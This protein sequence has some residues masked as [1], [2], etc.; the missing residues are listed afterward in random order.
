MSLFKKNNKRSEKRNFLNASDE[1]LARA[2]GIEV[3][4]LPSSKAKEATFYTCLRI[5]SDTVSKVPLKMYK[6]TANGTEKATGH[7]LYNKLKLRPNKNMSASDFWKMVEYQR[8]YYG[9]SVVVIETLPNGKVNGLHPLNMEFTEVWMDD[10]GIIGK[11]ASYWYVYKHQVGERI[12][13]FKFHSDEVLHFKGMTKDGI[14]GMAVKDY[15]ATNIEN[16]Q[17]GTKYTNEYFKGGLQA[18]GILQYTGDVD[19]VGMNRLKERFEKM[20]TGMNNV[21]KIL[22]VPVG[23]SF[24]TLNTSMAD[25]QFFENMKLSMQQIASAFG[26]KNHQLNDLSGAKFNNVASQNDE[27]YR[28]TLLPIFTAYEMELTYKLL[29]TKEIEEGMFFQFNV[30]VILRTSLETRYKAYNDGINGGFL[31]PNE[32]RAKEDLPRFDGAD[33]LMVNGSMVPIKDVGAAY[34]KNTEATPEEAP[35]GGEENE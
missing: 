7:Y 14:Q 12:Q 2:L 17:Y 30:D 29:T 22:P 35:K 20:A 32:V 1:A 27:F 8:N 31:T 26:I 11:D 16:L 23:F 4:G 5:L 24:Q 15:L 9:Q 13:E 19:E 28:D 6:E 21:G 3:H 33:V 18:K 34:Q 10:A 25:A